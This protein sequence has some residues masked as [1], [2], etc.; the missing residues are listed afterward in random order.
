MSDSHIRGSL[1]GRSAGLKAG[2]YTQGSAPPGALARGAPLG[3]ASAMDERG[4]GR[5]AA[6]LL[7]CGLAAGVAAAGWTLMTGGGAAG[8]PPDAVARVNER[9]ITR[10]AWL[11]AVAAVAEDRRTPLTPADR[12]AILQRLVDEELLLQ[13]GKDLGL[14]DNDRRLRSQLVSEV[15]AA[16]AAEAEPPDEAALRAYYDAHRDYFSTPPRLRVAA[17][18]GGAPF[19]PPV[20][21]AL[22]PPATL[23]EYLGPRLTEA[24]L[25]LEPGQA[26]ASGEVVLTV[27][28]REPRVV[29]P[30]EAAIE[31]VRARLLRERQEQALRAL[32]A[33]LR[34]DGQVLVRADGE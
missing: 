23:R 8:L 5:R 11:R 9:L 13:H 28:E 25:A 14:V 34:S 10:E 15:I 32:L 21:D 2:C 1:D 17:T 19:A 3:K 7:L 12:R 24:A 33:E 4:E 22:L 16:A 26:H 6:V 29:P 20:P 31:Q 30:F 18:S 27:L